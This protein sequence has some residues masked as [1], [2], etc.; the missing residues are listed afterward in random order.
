M[1]S[2]IKFLSYM[3]MINYEG[4]LLKPFLCFTW[5]SGVLLHDANSLLLNREEDNVVMKIPTAEAR[6]ARRVKITKAE[7]IL[8]DGND[9]RWN[10]TYRIVKGNGNVLE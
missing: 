8:E 7:F 9:V 2:L 10:L 1:G 5:V 3:Y 4:I 6:P